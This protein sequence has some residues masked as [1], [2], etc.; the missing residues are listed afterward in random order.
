MAYEDLQGDVDGFAT[1]DKINAV[2]PEQKNLPVIQE[3]LEYV[4]KQIKTHNSLD[5]IDPAA[6]KTVMSVQQQ[7]AVHKAIVIHLRAIEKVLERKF[8]QL[9]VKEIQNV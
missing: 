5:I 1:P 3:A 9:K 2:D 6:E 7:A 4:Q 8:E